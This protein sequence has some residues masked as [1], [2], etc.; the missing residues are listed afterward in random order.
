MT[1]SRI[2]AFFSM[3]PAKQQQLI[4]NA[5]PLS[6]GNVVDESAPQTSTELQEEL[7]HLADDVAV[8]TMEER[9][10]N[11]TM[12]SNTAILLEEE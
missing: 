9:Q 10:N 6:E 12:N 1:E 8:D 2:K 3:T 4:A 11:E 7:E 5:V